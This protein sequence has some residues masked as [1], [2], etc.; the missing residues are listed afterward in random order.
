MVGQLI[1][2]DA[3]ARAIHLGFAVFLGF[4]A[5]PALSKDPGHGHGVP[6]LSVVLALL[7]TLLFV[8]TITT[9]EQPLEDAWV[10]L[11]IVVAAGAA[12]RARIGDAIRLSL[13]A[14]ACH[15]FAGDGRALPRRGSF[16]D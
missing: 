13:P 4:L 12:T 8:L 11:A 16:D 15:V 3:E 10:T 7:P 5:F 14:G 1:F 6:V 9:G 2:N